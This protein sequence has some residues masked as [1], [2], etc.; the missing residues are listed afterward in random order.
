VGTSTRR[1][2]PATSGAASGKNNKNYE[3]SDEEATSHVKKLTGQR[4]ATAVL[5]AMEDFLGEA[6]IIDK[7]FLDAGHLV[8]A[9]PRYHPDL[10]G[11]GIEY[12]WGKA[13]WT[14][15]GTSTIVRPRILHATS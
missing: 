8:I 7:I 3:R 5:D 10:A 6:S 2:R 12:A 1:K 14:F 15:E 4:V 9:S 11:A 13:S